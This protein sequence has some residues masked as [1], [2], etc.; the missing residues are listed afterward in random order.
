MS[1]NFDCI[2]TSISSQSKSSDYWY[3][4]L[5]FVVGELLG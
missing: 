3:Y 4:Y 2:D 5:L 1:L